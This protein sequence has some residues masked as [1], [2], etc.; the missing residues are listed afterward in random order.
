VWSNSDGL[1]AAPG[2]RVDARCVALYGDAVCE[3]LA[4]MQRASLGRGR[5]P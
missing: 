5:Q 3:R 1:A 4:R 2:G